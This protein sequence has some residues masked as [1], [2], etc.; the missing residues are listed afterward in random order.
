MFCY[1]KGWKFRQQRQVFPPQNLT[2]INIGNVTL[3]ALSLFLCYSM[4]VYPFQVTWSRSWKGQLEVFLKITD[5]PG[6]R[7]LPSSPSPSPSPAAA[8]C[9]PQMGTP[10][11]QASNISAS[12]IRS[13]TKV[14]VIFLL[15]VKLRLKFSRH[16][17]C[18]E[19]SSH[20]LQWLKPQ[21]IKL[22]STS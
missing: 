18:R 13:I 5:F 8:F 17:W 3:H 22:K 11:M 19:M 6:R 21:K 14:I 4:F 7:S 2:I 12:V 15:E 20:R 1:L 9:S 10:A 16:C